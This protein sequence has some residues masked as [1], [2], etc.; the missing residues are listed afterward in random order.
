MLGNGHH[1]PG[2]LSCKLTDK[3]TT[4]RFP[5]AQKL[6]IVKDQTGLRPIG[7]GMES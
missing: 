4:Y 5:K 7:I 6:S 2:A 1:S 3:T